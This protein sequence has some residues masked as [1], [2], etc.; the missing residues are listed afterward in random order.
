MRKRPGKKVIFIVLLITLIVLPLLVLSEKRLHSDMSRKEKDTSLEKALLK[1][2]TLPYLKGIY[3]SP[4]KNNIAKA[5][6][7]KFCEGLNLYISNHKPKAFLIDMDGKV[8]HSWQIDFEDAFPDLKD[9]KEK[10]E[11][12]KQRHWRD[13]WRR[14]HLFDN[15]DLLAIFEGSGIIKLDKDSNLIWATKGGFHHD[16]EVV[17][18]MIYVLNRRLVKLPRINAKQPVLEDMVT[19]LTSEG[20]I[21]K[22]ISILEMFENSGFADLLTGMP[23]A[24]DIFHTNT[25]EILDGKFA[26]KSPVFRKG[27]ALLSMRM[28]DTI[29]IADLEAEKIAWAKKPGIWKTQ[30]QPT[31]LDNGNILVFNNL[32]IEN[33][34]KKPAFDL[35]KQ[36]NGYTLLKKKMYKD[37]KSSVMEFDPLTMQIIWEYIGDNKNKFFSLS[38]GSNQRLPNGNTL[39]T[40]ST[41]G[42][43]FE[44]TPEGEIVWEFTNTHRI[45]KDK[46][47]ISG[48][49][50]L[51]RVLPG[52]DFFLT[53]DGK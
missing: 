40:E 41:R 24:G 2:N 4:L 36:T 48:I 20:K 22:S 25:L 29:A 53:V 11:W 18:N 34:P 21:K 47:L 19:I 52:P 15:G 27:N 44:V 14:V 23:P 8:L 17:D 6:R 9:S 49:Q 50:E 30:H 43:V 37:N 12:H 32:Y 28:L 39:I 10:N 31:M 33:R 45:G 7:D 5:N 26:S 1:L 42:R 3:K 13:Y 16:L 35:L 38:S 51:I 46:Q